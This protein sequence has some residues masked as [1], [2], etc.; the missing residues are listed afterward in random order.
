M[1]QGKTESDSERASERASFPQTF[2]LA[3]AANEE[4]SI[5][6]K[7]AQM[8]GAGREEEAVYE[9]VKGGAAAL[10]AEE[11]FSPDC[12]LKSYRGRVSQPFRNIRPRGSARKYATAA[13]GAPAR[14]RTGIMRGATIE[15]YYLLLI[16]PARD[17]IRL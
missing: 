17:P 11:S 12:F 2:D 4:P 8:R 5:L 9:G 13:P 10:S 15:R 7:Q 14:E 16:R 3:P 1:M 6:M